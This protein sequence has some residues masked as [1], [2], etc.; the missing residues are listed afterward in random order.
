MNSNKIIETIKFLIVTIVLLLVLFFLI[1]INVDAK[2]IAKI[3]FLPFIIALFIDLLY[4]I[5][6][7]FNKPVQAKICYFIGIV[8]VFTYFFG[9]LLVGTIEV[10]AAKEY[11]SL[12]YIL[13][14]WVIVIFALIIKIRPP[15]L[16][17]KAK[18]IIDTIIFISIIALSAIAGLTCILL[19]IFSKQIEGSRAFP[20]L[21]GVVFLFASLWM[22]A[23]QLKLDEKI[24]FK[25][26]NIEFVLVSG[27]FVV[28]GTVILGSQII[29]ATL[30][31]DFFKNFNATSI[32]SLLF[33]VVGVLAMVQN[34]HK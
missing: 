21:F 13:P 30:I 33:I 11:S 18:E 6:R 20:I 34:F 31:M 4:Q 17:D 8:T 28:V 23:Y 1:T 12:F 3:M 9:M 25:N 22:L 19:G 32:I 14:F 16:S 24:S 26:I 29:S 27:C 2:G 15:Q 10:I 5:F 7:Y